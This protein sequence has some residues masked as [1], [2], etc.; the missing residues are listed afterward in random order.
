[1]PHQPNRPSPSSCRQVK[2]GLHRAPALFHMLYC[3]VICDVV[4][5][6]RPVTSWGT[7]LL[8]RTRI[9]SPAT[10]A[11]E[12][13]TPTR[14]PQTT[15]W[16]C[17][18]SFVMHVPVHS[19]PWGRAG[20]DGQHAR[21]EMRPARLRRNQGRLTAEHYPFAFLGRVSLLFLL[22]G[23]DALQGCIT[24]KTLTHTHAHMHT[25]VSPAPGAP[26]IAQRRLRTTPLPFPPMGGCLSHDGDPNTRAAKRN[27]LI[28]YRLSPSTRMSDI[29]SRTSLRYR[30]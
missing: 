22:S 9:K 7:T 13:N 20:K 8:I 14:T 23:L 19:L 29:L 17:I 26:Q 18:R 21:L 30:R 1:M 24:H 12:C 2:R 10:L 4:P 15:P 3:N 27:I 28:I 5:W 6:L 25:S 11:L 16:P